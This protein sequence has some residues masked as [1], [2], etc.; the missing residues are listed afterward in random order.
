MDEAGRLEGGSG[1]KVLVHVGYLI[2]TR[3]KISTRMNA[4]TEILSGLLGA[5][6]LIVPI[7]YDSKRLIFTPEKRDT[8]TRI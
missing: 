8:D 5:V 2:T 7:L 4:F 3:M 1:S 6:S